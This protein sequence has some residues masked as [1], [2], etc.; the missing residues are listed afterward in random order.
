MKIDIKILAEDEA[1]WMPGLA[2][3]EEIGEGV[4]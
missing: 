2:R 1:G 4:E 3:P